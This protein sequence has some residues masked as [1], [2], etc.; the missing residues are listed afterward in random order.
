MSPRVLGGA[1]LLALGLN[2]VVGVGIFFL[3]AALAARAPGPAGLLVLAATALALLPVALTFAALGRRFPEDGGPVLYARAAFGD[4]AA[5]LVGWIAYLSAVTSA[6]AVLAG[7][8]R[9]SLASWLGLQGPAER[10]AAVALATALAGLSAL[11]L[12]FSA[13]VWSFLAFLKLTPLVGLAALGL[14]AGGPSLRGASLPSFGGA[15]GAAL[16]AT[17]A[18]QG[19]EVIPVVAGHVRGGE[20][21]VP[22]AM[23]GSLL[24]AALLYGLLHG[25]CLGA[26]P[27]LPSSQAPLVEAARTLGGGRWAAVLGAGANLSALGIAFGM[28]AMTPRYLAALGPELG[29]AVSRESPRGVPQTALA[30]TLALVS[31]LL[32]LGSLGELLALSSVAVLAQYGV[33]ALALLRLAA[34]GQA[35]LRPR[36]A[37]PA[38]LAL[39]A[40]GVLVSGATRSEAA[41]AVAALAVGWALRRWRERR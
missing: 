36:D 22:R 41:V 18:F 13:G 30:V 5:F 40:T 15:A 32:A 8:C 19:F 26:V 11:G 20:R 29:E 7:L 35:G 17:F 2:G 4:S 38:P 24:L 37:W 28:V 39:A 10:A 33:T 27:G 34:R 3:P 9:Y 31:A 23:V 1:S 16:A 21:A 6:A 14:L 25:A 12:R